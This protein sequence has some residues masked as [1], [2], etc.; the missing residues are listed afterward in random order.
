MI[1]VL[2]IIVAPGEAADT[3]PSVAQ[4]KQVFEA[5]LQKLKPDGFA[6][7]SVLFQE[8]RPGTPNGGY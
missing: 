4:F 5:H 7:Q 8:A 2:L 3:Q 1:L 6:A